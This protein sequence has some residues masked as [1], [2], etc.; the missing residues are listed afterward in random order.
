MNAYFNVKYDQF[1]Q[2]K[3][4]FIERIERE[5]IEYLQEIEEAQ[6]EE[7]DERDRCFMEQFLPAYSKNDDESNDT[8]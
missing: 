2:P 7:R 1:L 8:W 6:R 5:T 4:E 3:K